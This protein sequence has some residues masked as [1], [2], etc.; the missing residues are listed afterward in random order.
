MRFLRNVLATL[1]GLIL[2]FGLLFLILGIIASSSEDQIVVAENSVLKIDLDQRPIVERQ[3]NEFSLDIPGISGTNNTP[4]GVV[5]IKQAIQA[6]KE[7]D[8]IRGIYL[9]PGIVIGGWAALREIR[10]EL[11]DFKTADKFVVAFN[12]Q[13]M[14]EQ[15]YYLSSVADEN[16]LFPEGFIEFNGLASQTVFL[17]GLLEKIGVE[18]RVF[19]VGK[20]KGAIEPL[21]RDNLSEENRAQIESFLNSIY[22]TYLTDLAEVEGDLSAQELRDI[23]DSMRVYLPAQAVEYGMVDALAYDDEVNDKLKQRLNL[24]EDDDEV[25]FISLDEYQEAI[26]TDT[27]Y[28][29][30]RVAVIVAEGEIREGK[31]SDGVIGGDTVGEELRKA[32]EDD[33]VKAVVLR[34]N[35]PGGSG[36]ASEKIW[37]EVQLMKEE[38]PIIASMSTYAASGGYYMAMGCDTIVAQP[39]T[40]TGSI[41]VFSVAFGTQELFNKLGLSVDVVKTG[42][43]AD[44]LYPTEPITPAEERI[45]QNSVEQFYETF[46][47]KAAQ[48]RDMSV[49]NIKE[50]ASGRVWT[51]A[52]AKER[53][54][55][56]V[57]GNLDDAVAIAVNRAGLE[58]DDYRV[59]YYP[60]KK[61]LIDQILKEFNL[62]ANTYRM[63]KELGPLYPY[64]QQIQSLQHM[65]GLQARL[66]FTLEIQ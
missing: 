57:L 36:T 34:I 19:R 43:L 7:D 48:G 61:P 11:I 4:V 32:R 17:K 46:V 44:I 65:Q 20:F 5:E 58:E 50:I 8:N 25:E 35:S 52:E 59:K 26:A 42:A 53:N 45:I 51:G 30:N 38:K 47:T 10:H 21:I 22:N 33:N 29:K 6:A 14:T 27:E 15:A 39:N 2:F 63:K 31:S 3:E 62:E 1:V 54:L 9:T 18:P 56:D 40:I 12:G 13:A 41:G 16:Y 37:R 64:V 66:P 23:A 28:S 60:E 49:E 24:E 55:V